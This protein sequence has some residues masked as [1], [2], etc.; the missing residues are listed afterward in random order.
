[1]PSGNSTAVLATTKAL[2]EK[3]DVKKSGIQEIVYNNQSI[4]IQ[5]MLAGVQ[6]PIWIAAR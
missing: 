3:Y 2:I 4:R 6:K 5:Q 1:M